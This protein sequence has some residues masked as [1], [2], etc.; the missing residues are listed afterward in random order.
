[1]LRPYQIFEQTQA[2]VLAVIGRS[3]AN[4]VNPP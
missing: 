1:V 3:V 4:P 2:S